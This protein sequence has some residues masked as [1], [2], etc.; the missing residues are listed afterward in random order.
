MFPVPR[1]LLPVLPGDSRFI[2]EVLN[3]LILSRWSRGFPRFIPVVPDGALV[4][5]GSAPVD[6]GSRTGAPPAS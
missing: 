1:R 5:P 6:P 3:I 4:N 2:Q